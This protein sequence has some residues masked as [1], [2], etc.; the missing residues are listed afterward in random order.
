[1]P[2]MVYGWLILRASLG[3]LSRC[4]WSRLRSLLLKIDINSL[5]LLGPIDDKLGVWVAYTKRQLGIAYQVSDIKVKVTVA[6]NRNSVS[7]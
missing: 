1:M 7:A 3:L 2:N 6:R 5:S 4:M